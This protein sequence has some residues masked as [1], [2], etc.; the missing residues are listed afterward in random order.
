MQ[1]RN[2]EGLTCHAVPYSNGQTSP[3][4]LETLKGQTITASLVT[5]VTHLLKY[6]PERRL[7]AGISPSLSKYR[8]WG[9]GKLYPN[10]APQDGAAREVFNIHLRLITAVVAYPVGPM[11]E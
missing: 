7:P 4:S 2:P 9:S 8:P 5:G 1:S 11:C 3:C 10:T 6:P